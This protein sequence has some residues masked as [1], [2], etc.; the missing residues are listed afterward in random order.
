MNLGSPFTYPLVRVFPL[1][2][3]RIILISTH[4]RSDIT[5]ALNKTVTISK[6]TPSLPKKQYPAEKNSKARGGAFYGQARTADGVCGG[7]LLCAIRWC[8]YRD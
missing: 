5:H 4:Q 7:M 6:D 8:A 2:H 3:P 1:Y